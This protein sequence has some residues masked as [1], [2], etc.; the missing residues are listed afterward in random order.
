MASE[1]AD[2]QAGVHMAM[3]G[4]S[5]DVAPHK[6]GG[7]VSPCLPRVKKDIA[8]FTADPPR[9]VYIV[10]ADDNIATVPAMG[11]GPRGTPHERAFFRFLIVC[12]TT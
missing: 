6:R 1:I 9:R 11:I 7:V 10:T 8:D 2:G 12:P 5:R 4:S 3:T